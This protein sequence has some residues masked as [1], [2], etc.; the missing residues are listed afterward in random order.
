MAA[1]GWSDADEPAETSED[2]D[3]STTTPESPADEAS[4]EADDSENGISRR[5]V[6][7]AGL[8]TVGGVGSAGWYLSTSSDADAEAEA[9]SE[10]WSFQTGN[11]V[12]SSPAVVDGTVYVGSLDTSVY[13]LSDN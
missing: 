5:G 3:E 8:L 7:V 13:A 1:R 11:S 6:L 2:T 12:R 10:Q 9:G 4:T